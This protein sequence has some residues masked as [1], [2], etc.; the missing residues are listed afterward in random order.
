VAYLGQRQKPGLFTRSRPHQKNDNAH[1]EQHNWTHVRQPFG[2][3]RYDNP[4]VAPPINA[5][6]KGPLGQMQNHFLPTHQLQEKR[7]VGTRGVRVYGP[8]QTPYARVLAAPAVRT[9]KQAELR[10]LHGR[11]NPFQLAWE[12]ERQKRAIEVQRQ[13]CA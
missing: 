1:V 9:G 8:A 2:Y 6:C 3:E 5:L 10:A 11:L 4:A 12:I 7:R 13:L